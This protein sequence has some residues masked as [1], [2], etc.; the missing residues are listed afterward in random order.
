MVRFLQTSVILF[1]IFICYS[2]ATAQQLTSGQTSPQA[3]Q[4]AVSNQA[5]QPQSP[6]SAASS[7]SQII[8]QPVKEN[9]SVFEMYVSEKTL[10]ITEKQFDIVTKF[11]GITFAYTAAT[12]VAGQI[13][14]PVRVVRMEGG[15]AT[16]IDINA[17]YLIG[18]PEA[19]NSAFKVLGI[20]TGIGVSTNIQQFGYNLFR[21]PSTFAPV[22]KVPVGP[23]YVLG[24][25]DEIK[26][27]VWGNIEG[28]WS[29]VVDR[30]GTIALPNIGIPRSEYSGS[31]QESSILSII[32]VTGLTFKELKDVIYKQYAKYY[33][34]FEINIAMGALRTIKIYV[35][36]NAKTPGA[37]TISSLSTLVNALFESGGPS[38]NGTMRDIQLKR[39]GKTIMH[40]DMYDLLLKG[41]KSKD[42]KLL[43]EDVVFI[44]HVGQLA[45]IAG[46]VRNPA[47]YELKGKTNL[48][49][50][51]KMAGGLTATAF[52]GRIQLQRIENH[53]YRTVLESDLVGIE[54][55]PKKNMALKDGDLIRIFSVQETKST[56]TIS[57]A[58]VSPGEYAIVPGKSRVSDIISLANGLLYFASNEAE[59]TRVKATQEGPKIERFIINHSKAMAGELQDNIVLETNDNLLIRAVPG[60]QLPE[61][62]T[63]SGEVKYPG[64]YKIKKGER[65]S[66]VIERAGGYS[67]YAYLRGAVFT[68]ERLREIQ[69]KNMEEMTARLEREL[70]SASASQIATATNQEDVAAKKAEVEQK[71]KFLESLRKL[72]ATGRL[73]IYLGHPRLLKG[74]EFDLELEGGDSLFIPTSSNIV[75]VAGSVMT[76]G[77]FI[78]S[79]S[80]G[81]KDYVE[82]AGG[83]S[84]WADTDNIYVMK[85][86]GSALKVARGLFSWS[87]A[88]SRWEIAAFGES[89]REV[90]PGDTIVVPEK[91]DQIA[92]LRE[93]KDITQIIANIAISAGVVK[94]LY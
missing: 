3:T 62:V 53:L 45:G 25:G 22:D 77:S 84:R 75:N 6:Q 33:T 41:D 81:T 15:F 85:A 94:A 70:M 26:I 4:S 76:Q 59:L 12:P 17:G 52:E 37:Y 34:G 74:S 87:S 66:S 11:R 63:I 67:D 18:T 21:A 10:E 38:K 39:H 64:I 65:L 60:W 48:I 54:N 19:I 78:Y 71:Q 23:D 61:S 56:V 14:I 51:I 79:E 73:T 47:I 16:P 83:V 35:V 5:Q 80:L 9:A 46:N 90:E 7:Q 2:S 69:Q 29:V 20:D 68:R 24:P 42:V 44:P 28:Q 57:G 13:A 32:G 91:V 40:F 1:L 92:W 30:D 72:K 88:R 58:V 31:S 86:D 55:N 50:L 36:G 27:T 93:I 89:A 49:D 82:L 8:S 43:P